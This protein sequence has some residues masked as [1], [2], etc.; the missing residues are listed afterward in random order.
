MFLTAFFSVF[1]RAE[2][3]DQLRE[4]VTEAN[5]I[6]SPRLYDFFHILFA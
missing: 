2:D 1:L 3:A 5:R 4:E 6:S